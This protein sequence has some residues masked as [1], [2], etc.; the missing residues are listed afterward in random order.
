M[1]ELTRVPDC[2]GSDCEADRYN[3]QTPIEDTAETLHRNNNFKR[4]SSVIGNESKLREK[5]NLRNVIEKWPR[6]EH[7][8]RDINRPKNHT[9]CVALTSIFEGPFGS[10]ICRLYGTLVT[11][12]FGGNSSTVMRVSDVARRYSKTAA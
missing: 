1:D 5:L 9:H 8:N 3:T 12:V 7:T 2:G 6:R 4:T 11:G 10:Q